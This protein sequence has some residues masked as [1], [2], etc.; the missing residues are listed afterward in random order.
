MNLNVPYVYFA[1]EKKVIQKLTNNDSTVL[2]TG[3]GVG[4]TQ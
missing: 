1:A 3:H 2:A 4:S